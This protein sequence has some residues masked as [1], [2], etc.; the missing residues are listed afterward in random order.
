[1]GGAGQ[2]GAVGVGAMAQRS[3][4][5][6]CPTRDGSRGRHAASCPASSRPG[7]GVATPRRAGPSSPVTPPERS[8]HGAGGRTSWPRRAPPPAGGAPWLPR[9]AS[10]AGRDR[11]AG[12]SW[13]PV[14]AA[15]LEEG[16][17]PAAATVPSSPLRVADAS[18]L[19]EPGLTGQ[20]GQAQ[21]GARRER[22]PETRGVGRERCCISAR[23]ES[24][25][26]SEQ[27]RAR[28][29]YRTAVA[30]GRG[31]PRV[32]GGRKRSVGGVPRDSA[33]RAALTLASS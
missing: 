11:R 21:A 7:A 33:V 4:A 9:G 32:C 8:A 16:V 24:P 26:N 6:P 10:R 3:G 29:R 19:G 15:G 27:R 20:G 5:R 28:A 12:A 14:G 25:L 1:M 13:T 23:P 17:R 18:R 22:R 31:S 2:P 30:P